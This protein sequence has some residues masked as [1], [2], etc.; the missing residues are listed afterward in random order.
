MAVLCEAISVI[1]RR[2]SIDKF[3]QGG[4][5]AFQEDLPHNKMCTDEE[6]V[7]L[8]FWD[9]QSVE[10][11]IDSLEN[12]GLQFES[13]NEAFGVFDRSREIND[14]AVIEQDTGL[15]R[16][17]DWIEQMRSEFGSTGIKVLM[18][19]LFEGHKIACGINIKGTQIR[20]KAIYLHT[21]PGWTPE[22][23]AG[24][25]RRETDELDN[26]LDFIETKGGNDVYRDRSTGKF[27]YKPNHKS[28]PTKH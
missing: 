10:E 6:L 24:L 25:M 23:S 27:W 20:D 17:C 8:G 3:Y 15:W 13:K 18:C 7:S 2:D 28:P 19:W 5:L 11:Y 21:P 22:G 12:K 14:I 16:P 1:V 4:W 26:E 9:S